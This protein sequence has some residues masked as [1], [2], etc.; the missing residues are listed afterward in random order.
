MKESSKMW[1]RKALVA[2][3]MVPVLWQST[4]AHAA[5]LPILYAS[6]AQTAHQCVVLGSA[7]DKN[8][9]TDVEGVI[10]ADLPTN[11]SS[12]ISG[13]YSASPE[14]EA[15]C[16]LPNDSDVEC[17]QINIEFGIFNGAG[18]SAG[19][20]TA[21][22]GYDQCGHDET[23]PCP[24]SGRLLITTDG[25]N[26]SETTY[27][28]STCDTSVSEPTQV[29]DVVFGS[30]TQ[31]ELPGSDTWVSLASADPNDGEN[32]STGHYFACP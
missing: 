10:C 30:G 27:T 31:I 18:Q 12:T 3:A 2:A 14:M 22:G 29:W 19:I 25:F 11:P 15:Y 13:D 7:Y 20:L 17:A 8:T 26:Y 16:Q 9:G 5:V 32:E 4:A 23:N 24:D 1:I 6:E 21:S 28:D